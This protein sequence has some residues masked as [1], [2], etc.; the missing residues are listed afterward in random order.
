MQRDNLYHEIEHLNS[1]GDNKTTIPVSL[2][3]GEESEISNLKIQARILWPALGFPSVISPNS[4]SSSSPML[5]GDACKCICVLLLSNQKYLSKADAAKYLRYVPW[6]ERSRRHIPAGQTGSFAASDIQ[7]RNELPGP[8]LTIPGWKDL[9]GTGISFGGD[10][11]G[12]NG[13]A[14]K[15]AN[16]VKN[17]YSKNG[18]QYLHEIRVFEKVSAQLKEGQYNLF[19][20]SEN[21]KENAPSAEIKLLLDQYALPKRQ[22]TEL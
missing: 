5:D 6:E 14:V 15:L 13:I 20:N 18:L 3:I 7:V 22:N 21:L 19:W 1:K 12:E 9:H 8:K 2:E 4:S 11:E 10:R 17:F 16:Y